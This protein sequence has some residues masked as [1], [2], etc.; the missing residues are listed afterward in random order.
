[1][2]KILI[3]KPLIELTGLIQQY[4]LSAK[5][6]GFA[7]NEIELGVSSTSSFKVIKEHQ[8]TNFNTDIIDDALEVTENTHYVY[9]RSKLSALDYNRYS[10]SSFY[11]GIDDIE[12]N[13]ENHMD[14]WFSPAT[15]E[16]HA[17]S[18]GRKCDSDNFKP[19][20]HFCWLVT[21]FALEFSMEDSLVLA[22]AMTNRKDNVPRETYGDNDLNPSLLSWPNSISEF[23]TPVQNDS[24]L[25]IRSA[26]SSNTP[27]T[28]FASIAKDG[29]GIYPIVSSSEWV[30]KLLELGVKTI[31]LRLKGLSPIELESEIVRSIELGCRYGGQVF[32][33]DYW[34][35][36][37]QHGAFGVH[38]G[39]EDLEKSNLLRIKQANL[40]LGIS[41]HGYY[42]LLRGLSLCPSYIAIGPIFHTNSKKLVSKPQGLA[43]LALYQQLIDSI[44]SCNISS[45]RL[46][47]SPCPTVAIGGIN[48]ANVEQVLQCGVSSI[49]LIGAI[50]ASDNLETTVSFFTDLL[51]SYVDKSKGQKPL[52]IKESRRAYVN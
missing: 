48:Q 29:L 38:L 50:S 5:K 19:K 33:N 3:P 16:T 45:G 32:I 30:K 15:G 27:D 42:E 34:E 14:I 24:R 12:K 40:R 7:I 46:K 20:E 28:P 11:I 17:L 35:L 13:T 26:R 10:P 52:S 23:P 6:Q 9:Y 31:Q 43:R 49:A 41:T 21:L 4:L 2:T 37:I 18:C 47:A 8:V 39:Q 22:R 25:C 51:Q 1:M 36:A 44:G